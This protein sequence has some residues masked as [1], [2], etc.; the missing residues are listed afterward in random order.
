MLMLTNL[1]GT[2]LDRTAGLVNALPDFIYRKLTEAG[3]SDALASWVDQCLAL[4][5]LLLLAW[6]I[7]L[8]V[9]FA[10]N[11]IVKRLVHFT[12][13]AWDDVFFEKKVFHKAVKLLPAILVY[14]L[15]PLTVRNAEV[16][17]GLRKVVEVLLLVRVLLLFISLSNSLAIVYSRKSGYVNKPVQVFFQVINVAA[18][19]IFG[20][21]IL[22][23]LINQPMTSL[24]AG[25]GA[26][27]AIIVLVFKDSI[28]GFI[29]GWQL[30]SNDLLRIGDWITVPKYGA[31]GDV[32][33]INL[34]SVK[35]RN[36]DKTITT[37][38]PYALISES[39]QN[40]RGME[41]TG[42]RRIKRSVYIDMKTIR[43]CDDAMME[44]FGKIAL[45]Q[46]YL[47]ETQQRLDRNNAALPE[48][49]QS[50][51]NLERQTNIGVFRAYVTAYLKRHPGL[52]PGLTSMVR[53]LQPTEKGLPL[54]IYCFVA[55]TRWVQY[56]TVQ[57]DIFDH[58]LSVLPVF[59]LS[60][61]QYPSGI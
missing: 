28:L 48:D 7:G 12:R 15:L 39:F 29:S 1:T 51:P 34:Y 27:M 3:V 46:P 59:G 53:Q 30:T 42:G 60:V 11:R 18:Y 38:P 35:V 50:D 8:L 6:L 23:V 36:F 2:E 14:L 26:S 40:W 47:Q 24:I 10:V 19:F 55:D 41:E 57:S 20:L 25:L 49:L 22:S 9:D 37:V 43:M 17:A 61:Y 32:I 44:R 31:D 4:A 52:N 58:I 13:A 5:L 56:E 54:E 45:L 16:V 33:E 21:W